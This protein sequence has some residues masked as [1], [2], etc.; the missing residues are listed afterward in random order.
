VVGLDRYVEGEGVG[1]EIGRKVVGIEGNIS[2]FL[3][4]P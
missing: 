3:A 4:E 2:F 1:E